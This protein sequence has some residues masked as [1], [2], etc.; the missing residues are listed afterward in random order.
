M[1]FYTRINIEPGLI[2]LFVQI[3]CKYNSGGLSV[4]FF[5]LMSDMELHEAVPIEVLFALPGFEWVA[6]RCCGASPSA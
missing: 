3:E 4:E 1:T 5:M 6:T 2:V